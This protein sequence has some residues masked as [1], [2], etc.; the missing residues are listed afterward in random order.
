M[1]LARTWPASLVQRNGWQRWFQLS[2]NRAMVVV[3][4]DMQ[5]PARLGLGDQ[6]EEG[7][8]LAVAVAG[9]QASVTWPVATSRA[10]NRVVVLCRT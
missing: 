4:H 10:A 2:Q 6:L 1:S 7:Q 8:E 5:L 3:H 9:M